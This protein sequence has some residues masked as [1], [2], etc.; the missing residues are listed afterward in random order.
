MA[1]RKDKKTI[2]PELITVYQTLKTVEKPMAEDEVL[3]EFSRRGVAVTE[4]EF[5]VNVRRLIEAGAVQK[6]GGHYLIRDTSGFLCQRLD[7]ALSKTAGA[8]PGPALSTWSY[9]YRALRDLSL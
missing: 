6:I 4:Q 7:E 2:T 8:A 5:R 3:G 9:I 1:H